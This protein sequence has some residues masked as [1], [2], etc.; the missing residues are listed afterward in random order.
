MNDLTTG[1]FWGLAL[2][3]TIG[4]A[5]FVALDPTSFSQGDLDRATDT[6]TASVIV[7]TLDPATT[8]AVGRLETARVSLAGLRAQL[9]ERRHDIDVLTKRAEGLD[10]TNATLRARLVRAVEASAQAGKAL[11]RAENSA[12]REQQA[13]DDAVTLRGTLRASIVLS[14]SLKPWPADCSAASATYVVR[15]SAVGGDAEATTARLG[16]P[17]VDSRTVGGD[18]SLTMTCAVPYEADLGVPDPATSYEI[19]AAASADPST[20]LGSVTVV[21]AD[22]VDGDGPELVTSYCPSC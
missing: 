13:L 12:A 14:P 17:R 18:G 11:A 3:A 22:V 15:V 19:S 2:G 21:G 6:A 20:A 1:G 9:G 10:T 5:A 16:S 4:A 7:P 8:A